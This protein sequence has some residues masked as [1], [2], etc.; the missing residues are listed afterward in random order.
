MINQS[1]SNEA[2]NGNLNWT[3][4][5]YVICCIEH[6]LNCYYW[7]Q[8]QIDLVKIVLDDKREM[9]LDFN[10]GF[11][12]LERACLYVGE[13]RFFLPS[14]EICRAILKENK[15]RMNSLITDQVLD[16]MNFCIR[17][18][19]SFEW[20]G[21]Y[22]VMDLASKADELRKAVLKFNNKR[23]LEDAKYLS[24]GMI[25]ECQLDENLKT[26]IKDL[27]SAKKAS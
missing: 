1:T 8:G 10:A 9:Y 14:G 18:Q 4:E 23:R 12:K 21:N 2:R 11:N 6:D 16:W 5:D 13:T 19:V 27:M 15:P 25:Y 20:K 22:V 24:D 3:V 26:L 17:N 7:R